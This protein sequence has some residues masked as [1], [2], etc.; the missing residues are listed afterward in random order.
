MTL[1]LFALFLFMA[2]PYYA[3]SRLDQ[4][5]RLNDMQ[6]LGDWVDLEAVRAAHKQALQQ[7]MQNSLGQAQDPVAGLLREGMQM[8]GGAAVEVSVDLEWVRG[9]LRPR[10]VR[11]PGDAYPSLL[12]HMGFGFFE[13]WPKFLVRI[14]ELGQEPVHFYLGWQPFNFPQG[15]GNWEDWFWK[16]GLHRWKVTAIY[17]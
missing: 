1:A 17:D 16:D 13:S 6:N 5:L 7:Q 10:G 9:S 12:K 14:G 2:S 3:L 11:E 4:A 8:L 15:G